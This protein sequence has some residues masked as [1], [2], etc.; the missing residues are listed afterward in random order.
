[1]P[2]RVSKSLKWLLGT[3]LLAVTAWQLRITARVLPVVDL[4]EYWSAA[5]LLVHGENPYSPSRMLAI[6]KS[7]GSN[8]ADPLLMWNPPWTLAFVAPMGWLS[9][10]A[11]YLLWLA[12]NFAI[13]VICANK[14]WIYYGGSPE[15]RFVAWII[16]LTFVPT[17]TVLGLGQ[18][19]PLILL[20]ITLFLLWRDSH[21]WLAGA[22]TVLI[23]IKPQ[24][25]YL[26]WIALLFWVI[27]ERRWRVL[28]GAAIAFAAATLVPLL[29]RPSIFADYAGQFYAARLLRNPSPNLGTLLRGW[30]S[31]STDWMQFVPSVLGGA[32][33]V[34]DW[35]RKVEW[36][37]PAGMP[38]LLVVSI[39]ST[40]YG[41][42]FDHVVLLPAV[43]QIATLM[44]YRR[45]ADRNWA[46]AVSYFLV[47]AGIVAC[48]GL[49]AVGIAYAWVAPAW[50]VLY[51]AALGWKSPAV[52]HGQQA[53]N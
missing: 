5:R 26:F 1:M 7:A 52:R 21:P 15:K 6:E 35:R 22:V 25:C 43:F 2:F 20:G 24:L 16:A 41:W 17:L 34:W 48:I 8:Q 51:F 37:W 9:Y 10:R 30:L 53:I 18:I 14:L 4:V 3:M 31:P 27:R 45:D 40:S 32:W 50:L 47:N 11:T 12:I 38:L 44:A 42:V 33:F 13:L 23:G 28:A 46:V 36:E 49:R 29:F 39:A 19:G